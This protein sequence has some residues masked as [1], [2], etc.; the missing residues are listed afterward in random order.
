M[1]V[2]LDTIDNRLAK[3]IWQWTEEKRIFLFLFA[4]YITSKENVDAVDADALSR[5]KNTDTEWKL[6]DRAFN[7]IVEKF[8][9][10]EID[11]FA[12]NNNARCNKYISR[13]PDPRA[14]SIDTFTSNW[15]GAY[16]YAFPPFAMVLK[17][18]SKIQKEKASGI[19]IVP[20]WP[21]QP[22]YPL[23]ITLAQERLVLRPRPDLLLSPCRSLSHPRARNLSL[24]AARVSG[25]RS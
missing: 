20:N 19:I 14:F 13:F 21:S 8:G 22:W 11:L 6:C 1:S 17:S 10:P 23:F 24:I 3:E 9:S 2:F 25:R 15:S 18:L 4:S 12:N 16:F 5:V 7:L